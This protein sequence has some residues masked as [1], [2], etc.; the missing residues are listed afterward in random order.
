MINMTNTA[1][2]KIDELCK[3]NNA[4]AVTL[5]VVGGGCAGFKY[6][7]GLVDTAEDLE[8]DEEVFSTDNDGKIAIGVMS[9]AYMAGSTIDYVS[10]LMGSQFEIKNPNSQGGCGCGTSVRF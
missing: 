7:W 10:D 5:N 1:K 2:A 8:E 9:L 6:V 3:N 4:Y